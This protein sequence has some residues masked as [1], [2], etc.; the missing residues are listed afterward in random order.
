MKTLQL[1]EALRA[2]A[3][4]HGFLAAALVELDG[5]MV[6]H[7]EGAPD[8]CDA[9]VSA[10]SDYWRL[11]RRS[12]PVFEKLGNLHVAMLFHRDGRIT[13]SACGPGML[14]VIVTDP[15][16]QDI[17]WEQWK[18]AHARLEKLVSAF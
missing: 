8:L 17:D 13:V 5:G 3:G 7:A 1:Q 18:T 2:M 15:R 4:Q 16:Q 12:Q 14:L 6:W 11:Y 10:A 9:V